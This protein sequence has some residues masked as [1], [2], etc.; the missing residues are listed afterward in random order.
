MCTWKSLFMSRGWLVALSL[1]IVVAC[2]GGEVPEPAMEE[3]TESVME[4]PA[5]PELT[6]GPRVFFVAPQDGGMLPAEQPIAFE[7][8]IENYEISPLPETVEQVRPGVGHHH[9]GVNTECLSVGELIPKADP[10]VHFGDGS[11]TI[12]M[13]LDPGEHTF[14]LQLGDDEHRTIEGLCATIT[15]MVEEGI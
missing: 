4:E 6:G 10:W 15:I 7:F 5:E 12:G 2:S 11:N 9:L 13:Q 14:A 8:G 1:A 3:S